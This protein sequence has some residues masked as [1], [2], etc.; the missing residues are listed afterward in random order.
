MKAATG[1]FLC[2]NSEIGRLNSVLLHRPG[3]ELERLTPDFLFDL[4]FDDIPWLKRIQEEHDNFAEA[5]RQNGT[6]VYYLE[7]LLKEVLSDDAAKEFFIYDLVSY[8]NTSTDIKKTIAGFLR[9]KTPEEIV[10]YAI[11]GLSKKDIPDIKP[12]SL[13]DYVYKDY[14]FFI[15]PL[16]NAYFMRDPAAVI[17]NGMMISSMKTPARHREAMLMKYIYRY[18]GIVNSA[19]SPLWYDYRAQYNIEGGDVLVLSS[20]AVAIGISERTSPQA[21]EAMALNLFEKNELLKEIIAIE[22]PRKRMF[23]HLDTVF[24][25]VDIDKF[26]IYPGIKDKLNIYRLVMGQS[27][28]IDIKVEEDFVK[29]LEDALNLDKIILIE[30]GG[31]DE[32]NGAREQ[33][34]DS[35]NTLAV[36]PGVVM[37]YNRNEITNN[38]LREYGIKVIE[39]EGSEL[40]RGRGGPRCMSM[41]LNRD[42]V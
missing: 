27:G 14:P 23:M 26:T 3:R 41:P 15:N 38:T 2:V 40:V 18:S 10:K 7:D 22:I 20:N 13:A 28:S 36:A 11:A 12:K 31:G 32:I 24:T 17:G 16:P 1:N 30:S 33:W 6:E 25:M 9:D 4:L 21:I 29:T 5:L 35:T 34:N 19:E 8:V 42:E 37:T 39:I